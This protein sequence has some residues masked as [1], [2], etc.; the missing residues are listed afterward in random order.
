MAATV[1][2][3]AQGEAMLLKTK[4]ETARQSTLKSI[5]LLAPEKKFTLIYSYAVEDE[6]AIIYSGGPIAVSSCMECA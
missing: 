3:S 5:P 1:I 6:R 4:Y 2:K